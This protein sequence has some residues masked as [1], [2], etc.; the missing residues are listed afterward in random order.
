MRFPEYF[1]WYEIA[2]KDSE[3]ERI[4]VEKR[5]ARIKGVR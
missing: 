3:R 2:V 1:E 5:A 4:D